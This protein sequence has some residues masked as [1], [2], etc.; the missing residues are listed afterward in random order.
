M[1]VDPRL[2]VLKALATP[3]IP[4]SLLSALSLGAKGPVQVGV[5][6]QAQVHHDGDGPGLLG[7]LSSRRSQMDQRVTSSHP[8]TAVDVAT[9]NFR[10]RLACDQLSHCLLPALYVQKALASDS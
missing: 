5:R 6:S 2:T 10:D 1:S 7:L 9:R 3:P 4:A 8:N